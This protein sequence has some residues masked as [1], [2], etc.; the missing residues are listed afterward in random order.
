[1]LLPSRALAVGVFLHRR[2]SL[3]GPTTKVS[4]QKPSGALALLAFRLQE[5]A[6]GL[7]LRLGSKV[8]EEIDIVIAELANVHYAKETFSAH[9]GAQSKTLNFP[10]QRVFALLKI[11]SIFT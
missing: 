4:I 9:D 7:S 11:V 1:M 8:F 6:F 3:A 2:C 5:I 10:K